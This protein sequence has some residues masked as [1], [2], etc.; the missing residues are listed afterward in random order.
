MSEA[1]GFDPHDFPG[2]CMVTRDFHHIV[3]VNS[4]FQ[5][6]FGWTREALQGQPIVKLLSKASSI[7]LDSY[8]IPLLLAEGRCEEIR[9]TVRCG[10]GGRR[11]AAA[12]IRMRGDEQFWMVSSA[13]NRDALHGELNKTKQALESR[14]QELQ[15]LSSTDALTGLFNRR[16]LDRRMRIALRHADERSDALGVL[17]LDVDHFK[18]INDTQGHAAG[19]AVLKA[20][21]A[22]LSEAGRD[23]D[24][25]GRFGGEEFLLVLP[26]ADAEGAL[27]FANRLLARIRALELEGL[28]VTA[29][30]GH[31]QFDPNRDLKI[32]SLLKRADEALYAAKNAGR[33]RAESKL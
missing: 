11:A 21:G 18:R 15:R 13:T 10:D 29:S 26:G 25:I 24:I 17:L 1:H 12:N 22:L 16:E 7:F 28:T 2:G 33:D 9:V 31:T 5:E 32:E 30:I 27:T 19:D 20:L 8:I 23:A 3:F 6:E 14:A 4:Y